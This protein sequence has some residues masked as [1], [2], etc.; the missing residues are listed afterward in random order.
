MFQN[1]MIF[2]LSCSTNCRFNLYKTLWMLVDSACH[3]SH[4][5]NAS[6]DERRLSCI[7]NLLISATLISIIFTP[8]SLYTPDIGNNSSFSRT[9]TKLNNLFTL[10]LLCGCCVAVR[11]I[12]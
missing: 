7:N 5:I 6:L 4:E 1:C 8:Y 10:F 12:L 11:R 3:T 2:Y 9:F